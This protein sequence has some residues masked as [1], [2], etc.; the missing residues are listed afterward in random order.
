[1]KKFIALWIV[2]FAALSSL[3]AR[4]AI[5][6]TATEKLP[7][8]T[9]SSS[10]GLH[11]DGFN[12]SISD[13]IFWEDSGRGIIFFSEEVTTIGISAFS[14]CTGLISITIPNSVTSIGWSAFDGCTSLTKIVVDDENQVYDSRDN[15]NAIIETAT[16]TLIAGCKTTVIPNSVTSIGDFAFYVCDGLISITI[17]NSVTSIGDCAF[18]G[19][20]N[21]TSVTIGNSVTF[22]GR[23]AF[24]GCEGLKKVNYTGDIKGWLS[25][26]MDPTEGGLIYYSRNLYLND[27]LLTEVVIP[28]GFTEIYSLMYDTCLV[29]VTI[30]NSV[31]E[32]SFYGCTS[33]KKVNYTGD[34]KG[35]L[36]IDN[37][38]E[39]NN[40]IYY[41]RNLYL[42]DV[43]LT[44]LV[45]PDGITEISTAF[46]YDTCLTSVTIPHSVT[47][48]GDYAFYGCT[49]IASVAIN[50]DRQLYWRPK[51][52]F[53]EQVSKYVLGDSITS[54]EDYAF[55]GYTGL[56]S[57]TIGNGVTSIGEKA[58]TG[59]TNLTSVTIDSDTIIRAGYDEDTPILI[60]T[61]FG[62][63]V[64]EYIIGNNVKG[65]GDYVFYG[66][67]GLVS[68]TIPNSVTSIGV[69]AFYGCTGLASV[70]I[71]NSVT[72]IGDG[73]F[74]GCT[75]LKKVNY[76]GD[77]KGWLSIEMGDYNPIYYSRNLYLNDVLLTDLVIPDGFTEIYS[78]MYDTCLVSV[79]IPNSVTEMSFYGC[80]GL[81]KV[82]YTGDVKDWLSIDNQDNPI[83]YSR[84]L[85]LNDVLLT[86]LV[87]PDGF[88]EISTAFAYDTC[89][90]S[91]TFP[92]GVTSIGDYAFCG[93]SGLTSITIPNNVTSIG[94]G[95]FWDCTGLTSVTINSD[96]IVSVNRKSEKSESISSIFGSQVTEYILGE[97]VH[98]IGNNTFYGN[99]NITSVT[100]PNSVTSIGGGAFN[101]CT[102]L[103]S[104]TIPNNVTSIGGSAFSGCTGL[105]SVMLPN[106]II[107]IKDYTFHGCSGLTSITI[108]NSVT[109][110]G[111]D[112]FSGC[113]G[114][115]YITIPDNVTSIGDYAFVYCTQLISVTIGKSV[116]S[117][118]HSAFYGCTYLTSII[119]R[120]ITPPKSH[121]D[122]SVI[123]KTTWV[124]I[125]CGTEEA[126]RNAEGWNF[127]LYLYD[128]VFSYSLDVISQNEDMGSVEVTHQPSC[129]DCKGIF[130]AV[131]NEGYRFV[132]WNDGNT[133]NPRTV[134]VT[135]DT[136]FVAEF[137]EQLP[138]YTI[139]VTCD[140]KQGTVS[141]SGVYD[142]GTQVTLTAT[143]NDGYEFAQWS[144][145]ATDNPYIFTATQDITLEARFAAT[146]A[147]E[148][149][150]ADGDTA[151]RKIVRDGQVYILR[152][153]KVYTIQGQEIREQ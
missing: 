23:Q 125:P 20:E 107:S 96:S 75:G 109:S 142:E 94:D 15:C 3:S 100:I 40:P 116:T 132:R 145:G 1:M 22:I 138:Q 127:F 129:F 43:L 84:N 79:T 95:A 26:V 13:H 141:G 99:Y 72:S 140:S 103:T 83:Y 5:S 47:S 19:C 53:G 93:C 120:A 25:I 27:V 108:P 66:C 4:T 78:L 74:Y 91:V 106:S 33:L 8:A 57:I 131:A 104:V 63:Q 139:T 65:I 17:P 69:G 70:T 85:Y 68:V 76:T 64:T 118:G 56:T 24:E 54:I 135:Q 105:T 90:T 121:N 28:D 52:I 6:Y 119:V 146:T 50:S 89:L 152:N 133:D 9:S 113:T 144:N 122:A 62:E 80:T 143:A 61:I 130:K 42:N 51:Y 128:D 153:G 39:E 110:I 16:N 77:V 67:T 46:S 41:S 87:I 151:V 86:D 148:N 37:Q 18:E 71:P 7:I 98:S 114:L 134:V 136:T 21:L 30:P 115:T 92:H 31:T 88:T 29:S 35:W 150:S 45:I 2:A 117:I 32:M 60:K 97:D 102:S 48:I 10:G 44:D 49:K 137:A 123:S 14:G 149:I 101:G 126:Y 55:S 36:S 73:T 34:V 82:N 112:A 38:Y 111:K 147:I 81:K 124:Y 58:F 59:C 11:I 12:T